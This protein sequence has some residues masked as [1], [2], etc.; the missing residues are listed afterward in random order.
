M[1][2]EAPLSRHSKNSLIIAI[3]ALLA[4][5]AWTVYDGFYSEAFKNEH[6]GEDGQPD[7]TLLFNRTAPPFLFALA[8]LA[9]LRLFLVR[10][11]KII[12][13][14]SDLVIDGKTSIAYDAIQQIDKTHFEKKGFFVVSYT[15]AQGKLRKQRFDDRKYDNMKEVLGHLVAQIS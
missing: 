7:S 6:T 2:I 15:D 12:A 11:R 1:A 9:G 3:V 14:E 5:A 8:G 4:F 13:Q 10:Q